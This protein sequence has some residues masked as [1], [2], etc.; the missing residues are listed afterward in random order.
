MKPSEIKKVID[1]P[2]IWKNMEAVEKKL[3]EITDSEYKYLKK[4]PSI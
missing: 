4:S 1:I 3:L 2:D